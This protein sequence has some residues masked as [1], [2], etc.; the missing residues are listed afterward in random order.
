MLKNFNKDD[1]CLL[2]GESN[3]RLSPDGVSAFFL[4]IMIY[5]FIMFIVSWNAVASIH[6]INQ[7]WNRIIKY[8]GYAIF[9]QLIITIYYKSLDRAYK[10]QKIQ[11]ILL[12]ILSFIFTI[13]A[14][15]VYFLICVDRHL[16]IEMFYMGFILI[17]I[18]ILILIIL[19]VRS[20]YRVKKGELRH[21]GRYI[22]KFSDLSSMKG[23][24]ISV[25]AGF[26]VAALVIIRT[27]S[28]MNNT[29]ANYGTAIFFLI[30]SVLVQYLMAIALPEFYL[31]T[32]CRFRF[33]NFIEVM[34]E[35]W[36]K[37]EREE[38]LRRKKKW[39]E[40]WRKFMD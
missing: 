23:V 15:Q 14:Y 25:I 24:N 13:E 36:K 20:V 26:T 19:S 18:G 7:V 27:L 30:I 37:E 21:G 11:A 22:Y 17:L 34:P 39:Q 33:S 4:G 29:G 8:E 6:N 32:Y 3:D 38:K 2:K 28:S 40:R 5:S 31:L 10:H 9:I 12:D 1:F 16:P 35:R